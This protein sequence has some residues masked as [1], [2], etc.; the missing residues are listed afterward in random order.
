MSVCVARASCR[1]G[2]ERRG[3]CDVTRSRGRLR[4]RRYVTVILY[5]IAEADAIICAFFTAQKRKC[6]DASRP[7]RRARRVKCPVSGVM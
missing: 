5:G 3:G 2:A 1:G 4:K 7:Q 6:A